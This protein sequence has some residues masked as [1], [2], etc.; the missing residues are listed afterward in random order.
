MAIR[1][2]IADSHMI[3][4]YGLR[5]FLEPIQDIE[6]IADVATVRGA[7]EKAAALNPDVVLMDA[8]M[9]D[10]NGLEA[11]RAIKQ[12]Q[13]RTAILVLASRAEPDMCRH[14]IVAGAAG[15]LVAKDL[16]PE[17][18]AS[19]IRA[20]H[21]GKGMIDPDIVRLMV[22]RLHGSSHLSAA[23]AVRSQYGLTEREVEI[24]ILVAQG[25]SDKEI[26]AQLFVSDSTVKTHLRAIYGKLKLRNRAHAA[27]FAVQSRLLDGFRAAS[28]A[29]RP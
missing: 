29:S 9:P 22:E 10:G 19:S 6:V 15:Y 28:V 13:P 26:A 23:A 24:L 11:I 18:L 16:T 27:A 2:L 1:V 8:A 12:R 21:G 17:V 4:R 14:A 25:L 3:N 7:I 20:A 5:A